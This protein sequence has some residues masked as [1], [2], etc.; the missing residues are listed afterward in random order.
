MALPPVPGDRSQYSS[1]YPPAPRGEC[2]QCREREGKLRG[3]V[4]QI[5]DLLGERE[6][7]RGASFRD[8]GPFPF[9]KPSFHGFKEGERDSLLD[10]EDLPQFK[11]MSGLGIFPKHL[12]STAQSKRAERIWGEL[13]GEVLRSQAC[14]QAGLRRGFHFPHAVHSA[15]D[16]ESFRAVGEG[17]IPSYA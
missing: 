2:K 13:E 15:R 16:N 7:V 5:S 10:L 4:K 3:I 17:E 12:I 6:K 9:P 8:M 1:Q 11:I 14:Q